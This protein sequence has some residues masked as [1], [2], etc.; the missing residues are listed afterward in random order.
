MQ[1]S[2]F[3]DLREQVGS[4][5]HKMEIA[6]LPSSCLLS[7]VGA[8]L[9]SAESNPRRSAY[10]G[11]KKELM[12]PAGKL[13]I[14]K[15]ILRTFHRTSNISSTIIAAQTTQI[16]RSTVETVCACIEIVM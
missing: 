4:I 2:S 13:M 9:S 5:G 12:G 16:A 6:L 3:A 15:L 11:K 8:S 7:T 1:S 14:T 10:Q